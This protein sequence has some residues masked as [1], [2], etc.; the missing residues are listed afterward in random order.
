MIYDAIAT[1]TDYKVLGIE[2]PTLVA[3]VFNAVIYGVIIWL[4]Y[5]LFIARKRPK[6][7]K[8]KMEEKASSGPATPP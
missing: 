1:E 6:E 2:V 5:D 7:T 8:R 3:A 4:I